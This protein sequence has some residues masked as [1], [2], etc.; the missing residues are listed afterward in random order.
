MQ[1]VFHNSNRLIHV[2]WENNKK[3]DIINCQII[4]LLLTNFNMMSYV[5]VVSEVGTC[6]EGK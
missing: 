1:T 6:E 3:L 2:S 4:L 5:H